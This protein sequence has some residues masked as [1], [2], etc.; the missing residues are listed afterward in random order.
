MIDYEYV[1]LALNAI[2]C[3]NLVLLVVLHFERKK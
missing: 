1:Q 3:A 2:G